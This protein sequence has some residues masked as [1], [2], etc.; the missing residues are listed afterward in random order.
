VTDHADFR[1]L[2]FERWIASQQ[3]PTTLRCR[4]D[5]IERTCPG[6]PSCCPPPWWAETHGEDP[7]PRDCVERPPWLLPEPTQ[8]RPEDA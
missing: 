1:A 7:S 5:V 3:E 4:A 2:N 8:R 6:C